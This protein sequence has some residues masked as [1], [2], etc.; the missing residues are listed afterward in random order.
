MD[1]EVE[2]GLFVGR[3]GVDQ[4]LIAKGHNPIFPVNAVGKDH[5]ANVDIS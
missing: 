5:L 1:I 3:D 2:I 4:E